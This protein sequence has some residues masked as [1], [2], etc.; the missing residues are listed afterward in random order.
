MP[1]FGGIGF[2]GGG[3]VSNANFTNTPTGTYSADGKNYKYIAFTGS[4]TLT[5]DESGFAD[6]LIVSGGGGAGTTGGFVG[7]AGGGGAAYQSNVYLD[8]ISYTVTVG[9]G[10]GTSAQGGSSGFKPSTGF[11]GVRLS[12]FGGGGGGPSGSGGGA[13]SSGGGGSNAAGGTAYLSKAYGGNGTNYASGG[14]GGDGT[15]NS[16]V[17]YGPGLSFSITGSAITYGSG[18]WVSPGYTPTAN[19]GEGGKPSGGSG[20]SGIVIVRVEV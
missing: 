5:I 12:F 14:A 15:A 1:T 13:G 3:G 2:G 8:A 18:N 11:D 10:G 16:A 20:S 7:G 17:G 6:I 9:A 19:R 4:G